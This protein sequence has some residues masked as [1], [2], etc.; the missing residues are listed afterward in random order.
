MRYIRKLETIISLFVK[1]IP[2]VLSKASTIFKISSWFFASILVVIPFALHLSMLFEDF[3]NISTISAWPF[4]VAKWRGRSFS[5]SG[6]LVSAEAFTNIRVT[7]I[8]PFS[9]AIER[10]VFA[11]LFFLLTRAPLF[12]N[13]STISLP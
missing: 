11:F 2:F 12:Y 1:K 5:L 6:R 8:K 9:E 4:L 10:G 13:F 7:P 3:K